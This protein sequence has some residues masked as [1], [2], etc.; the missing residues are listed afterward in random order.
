[1]FFN[2][3]QRIGHYELL[4]STSEERKAFFSRLITM[5]MKTKSYVNGLDILNVLRFEGIRLSFFLALN[6]PFFS[7]HCSVLFYFDVVFM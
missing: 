1:M 2:S 5:K 6:G 4:L 7:L 3:T